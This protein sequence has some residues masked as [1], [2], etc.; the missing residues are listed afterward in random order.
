MEKILNHKPSPLKAR[1]YSEIKFSDKG[2]GFDPKYKELIFTIFQRL[3]HKDLY[4]GT[5]IGL[6]L[7]KRIMDNHNGFILCDS[8]ENE[9]AC[10][11]VYFPLQS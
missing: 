7:C 1:S 9:G 3:H 5:G 11:A 10:F 4:E 2:I 6:A 8:K